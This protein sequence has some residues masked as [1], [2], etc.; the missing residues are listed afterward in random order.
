MKP[1]A[2]VSFGDGLLKGEVLEVVEEGNRLIHFEYEG[3]FEEI[4]DQLGQM[5]LPPYI[6]HQLED[7]NRYQTVCKAFR[8]CGC[9][10]GRT[11]FYTGASGRNQSRRCGDCACN[12]SCRTWNFPSGKSG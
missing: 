8:I 9:S 2:R 3:I 11:A 4:L 6:T 7:K 5:P 10:D 1:G 12:A